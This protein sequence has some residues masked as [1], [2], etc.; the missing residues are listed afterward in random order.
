MLELDDLLAQAGQ[1]SGGQRQR[2]AMGRA[3][4][5]SRRRSCSTSRSR[6]STPSCATELRAELKRLHARLGT[7][8]ST[9]PTTRSRR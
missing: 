4:S 2:V 3:L 8:M 6:I 9:S 7:T 1:L 5:A